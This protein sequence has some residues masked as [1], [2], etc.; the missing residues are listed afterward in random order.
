MN[1]VMATHPNSA[2]PF[3][4]FAAG[5]RMRCPTPCVSVGIPNLPNPPTR[6]TKIT[7]YDKL[8]LEANSN[9]NYR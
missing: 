1:W 7:R 5:K 9:D 8:L 3:T 4:F 6:F 2:F